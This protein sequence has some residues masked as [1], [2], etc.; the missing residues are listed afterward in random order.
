MKKIILLP[1]LLLALLISVTRAEAQEPTREALIAQIESLTQILSELQRKVSAA[2]AGVTEGMFFN[3]VVSLGGENDSITLLQ[4]V[5]ASDSTIYPEA[6]VTGYFGTL[7]EN[8]LLRF[9]QVWNLEETGTFTD[10]TRYVLSAAL[11]AR[12]V[13]ETSISYL[14]NTDVQT[15]IIQ[16]ASQFSEK[17][18]IVNGQV[19]FSANPDFSIGS[20]SVDTLTLQ[21]I[22]ATDPTIYPERN[23]SGFYDTNTAMAVSRLQTK[24]GIPVSTTVDATTLDLLKAILF[25]NGNSTITSN[26]LQRADVQ[27]AVLIENKDRNLFNI[28]A[29]HDYRESNIRVTVTY[30]GGITDTFMLFPANSPLGTTKDRQEIVD[31]LV[32]HLG[33]TENQV[34]TFLAFNIIDRPDF[35]N[36]VIIYVNLLNEIQV[37]MFQESG[38]QTN[39]VPP[40]NLDLDEEVEFNNRTITLGELRGIIITAA[41]AG[42]PV[43]DEIID[44]LNK[45]IADFYDVRESDVPTIPVYY[46]A[47]QQPT[48]SS[49]G[50]Y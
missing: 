11:A 14:Q 38:T 33:R 9:Q 18:L 6:M 15:A 24:Y 41:R 19:A 47:E 34:D 16:A 2:N 46:S 4:R 35:P 30:E 5:L 39:Y 45:S 12:P 49:L 1:V 31:A 40:T 3:E 42:E 44:I 10:E 28:S 43:D 36:R 20:R 32:T 21:R 29:V 13:N 48:E 27:P 8:A 22:L 37:F 7:T 50:N 26:L 17:G 25:E 23:V